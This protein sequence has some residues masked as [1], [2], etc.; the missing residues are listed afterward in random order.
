MN[1]PRINLSSYTPCFE[2]VNPSSI[3][4]T[5]LFHYNNRNCLYGNGWGM[6]IN[7]YPG[8]M[9]KALRQMEES[10]KAVDFV[11]EVADARIPRSSRNPDFD[12]LFR[13]KARVIVLNKSDLA[14]P[15]RT[16]QWLEW[17]AKRGEAPA[18]EFVATKKRG[19]EE[20]LERMREAAREKVERMALRGAKKTVRALVAGI[21]NTGK[22]ALINALA[23]SAPARTGNKP[24]VTRGRQLIRITPW[25]EL[26]DTPGVLWPKLDDP[27]GALDLAFTGAVREES[28]EP[29][30]LA[31]ELIKTLSVLYPGAISRRY[32]LEGAQGGAAETL[33]EIAGKRGCLLPGGEPDE[34]RAA[35][36]VLD[37]MKA[38]MLGRMTLEAPDGWEDRE[39]AGL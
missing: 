34:E 35:R 14:D 33:L 32:K 38:G 29:Y 9:A 23:G 21:P 16:K 4:F 18:V 28:M 6:D 30:R 15:E 22:S 13:T 37:E 39:P 17:Y 5:S 3:G 7:W 11:I 20:L 25:M 27:V 24:G 36:M 2:I 31:M 8:H 10:L 12:A 19:R 1:R 26:M